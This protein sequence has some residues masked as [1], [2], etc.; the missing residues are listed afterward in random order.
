[1]VEAPVNRIKQ[2][3]RETQ[4]TTPRERG[5]NYI[6]T[7]QL[8]L[9]TLRGLMTSFNPDTQYKAAVAMLD[10][11]K[12]RLRHNHPLAGMQIAPPVDL[13]E[14][15]GTMSM[16]KYDKP[17]VEEQVINEIVDEDEVIDLDE[18]TDEKKSRV[19]GDGR[20]SGGV[21]E[22]GGREAGR[23]AQA[24]RVAVVEGPWRVRLR[25]DGPQLPPLH[26]QAEGEGDAAVQR[27]HAGLVIVDGVHFVP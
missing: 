4:P 16:P 2:H 8:A 6:D 20:R 19:Q 25:D 22:G 23:S 17:I 21:F 24:D 1:M 5:T 26:G 3:L 13:D 14:P 15:I 10:I 18:L 9:D 7:L 27:W 12:T 11:E